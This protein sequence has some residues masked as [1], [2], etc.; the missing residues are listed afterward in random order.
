[1][2]IP[3][4]NIPTQL[5]APAQHR[6]SVRTAIAF[7]TIALA[8]VV[9]AGCVSFPAPESPGPS[10]T[11]QVPEPLGAQFDVAKEAPPNSSSCDATQSLRPAA[12]QPEP[13]QM[14]PGSTMDAIFR[15]GRLIVGTDIGSNLFSFRDP[16]TGDIQGFD[17]DL[18]HEIS[19]AIF[20]DPNRIEFRVLSSGERMDALRNQEVDLSLIH[21]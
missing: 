12:Q 21:I 6:T 3:T 7:V 11:A 2:N 10:A 13:A 17:V 18:A 19:R 4:L 5:N 14:P 20:N 15:R 1:M 16:I 8:T 9:L